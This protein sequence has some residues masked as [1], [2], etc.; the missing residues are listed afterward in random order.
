MAENRSNGNIIVFVYPSTPLTSSPPS[1]PSHPVPSGAVYAILA[2][3]MWGLLPLYWKLFGSTPAVEVLSHRILWSTVFLA[4]LL[5]VQGKFHEMEGV[6]RSPRQLGILLLTA[7]ILAGNW[8]LYIYAVNTDQVIETSLGYYINPLVN[9]LLGVLFLKE[10]LNRVQTAAV[11]LA[12]IGVGFFIWQ[13]G[14]PPW[15][16]LTLAV[17]FGTYG[18]LRKS[19]AIAP[20]IGLAVETLLI[21]PV[22]IGLLLYWSATG[23]THWGEST[24]LTLLFIGCGVITSLPLLCFNTAAKRLRLSTLGFFQYLAPT[25]QLL[26]GV[27]FYQEPFTSTHL[28]TFALV[29]SAIA[30]YVS[31][32]L[33]P[34]HPID[35]KPLSR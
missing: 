18:L 13:I 27:F 10:R 34:R 6:W 35:H 12:A 23:T 32:S 33:R 15:I 2:Y 17:S 20:T 11:A 4:G 7:T 29:W 5:L 26:L 21:T 8:G 1:L 24:P 30:L 25:L 22:A 31:S 16:A 14:T 3:G 9:V 19:A 28:I